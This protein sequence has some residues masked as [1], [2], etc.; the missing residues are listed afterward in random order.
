MGGFL[1]CSHFGGFYTEE[2]PS[3][4]WGLFSSDSEMVHKNCPLRTMGKVDR[5]WP[6]I[7]NKFAVFLGTPDTIFVHCSGRIVDSAHFSGLKIVQVPANCYAIGR[8]YRLQ[9]GSRVVRE[10][11]LLKL[12][13]VSLNPEL[14]RGHG[15]FNDSA[16]EQLLKDTARDV[17]I[18]TRI[19]VPVHPASYVGM[20]CGAAAVVV[21]VLVV[22]VLFVKWKR[23][24]VIVS[25]QA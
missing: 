24:P 22:L 4:L 10:D 19:Q 17:H 3:C 20:V 6:F 2:V 21:V 9:A 5:F 23:Q 15:M 8:S 25:G 7:N 1:S 11:A 16:A 12:A 13:P 14:F 18:P